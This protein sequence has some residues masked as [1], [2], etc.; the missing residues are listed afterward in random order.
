[1]DAS[2]ILKGLKELNLEIEKKNGPCSVLL[3]TKPGQRARQ[4]SIIS[5]MKDKT[6]LA[7]QSNV[8]HKAN[9]DQNAKKSPSS[10]MKDNLNFILYAN[11]SS[12]NK[13]Y[14]LLLFR[15]KHIVQKPTPAQTEYILK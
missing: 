8:S 10:G 6:H 11:N 1:M 15:S 7:P 14:A 4:M 2:A 3:R 5:G 12:P 13:P 9:Q